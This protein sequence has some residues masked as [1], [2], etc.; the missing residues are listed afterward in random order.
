[1]S[2]YLSAEPQRQ[3][4]YLLPTFLWD[5]EYAFPEPARHQSAKTTFQTNQGLALIEH[6]LGNPREDEE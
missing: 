4:F 2:N 1:M 6:I 5:K 3:T